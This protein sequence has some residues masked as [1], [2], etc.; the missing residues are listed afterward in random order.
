MT[1][2]FDLSCLKTLAMTCL[3]MYVVVFFQLHA[4]TVQAQA[5]TPL[6]LTMPNTAHHIVHVWTTSDQ[7]QVVLSTN[8]NPYSPAPQY[9]L[10]KYSKTGQLTRTCSNTYFQEISSTKSRICRILPIGDRLLL[11]VENPTAVEKSILTYSIDAEL[12]VYKSEHRSLL[13][14]YDMFLGDPN[15]DSDYRIAFVSDNKEWYGISN[16]AGIAFF[17]KQH[18]IINVIHLTKTVNS[19]LIKKIVV[20]NQ[21][22]WAALYTLPKS[23]EESAYTQNYSIAWGQVTNP[24]PESVKVP[25]TATANPDYLLNSDNSGEITLIA[26]PERNNQEKM[27]TTARYVLDVKK[28]ILEKKN[29]SPI[30]TTPLFPN[31]ANFTAFEWSSPQS[32]GYI[33]TGQSDHKPKI[34]LIELNSSGVLVHAIAIATVGHIQLLENSSKIYLLVDCPSKKLCPEI[35][36]KVLAS[37]SNGSNL[38]IFEYIGGE[39]VYVT[40]APAGFKNGHK[41]SFSPAVWMRENSNATTTYRYFLQQ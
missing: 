7:S 17:N 39:L 27:G 30:P 18:E 1:L 21:G 33:I 23:P 11:W 6:E 16:N 10:E 22:N 32:G 9:V 31:P 4:S 25:H 8:D 3:Q 24:K 13:S 19:K 2:K 29:V 12:N 37:S 40:S 26:L 38:H 28:G 41:N 14:G 35:K 15:H 5:P 20:D 34:G 36:S